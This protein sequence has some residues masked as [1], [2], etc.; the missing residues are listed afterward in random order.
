MQCPRDVACCELGHNTYT[1]HCPPVSISSCFIGADYTHLRPSVQCIASKQQ[2]RTGI[3][4][5]GMAIVPP[6]MAII[7]VFPH[8][9]VSK[10][11]R[12]GACNSGGVGKCAILGLTVLLESKRPLIVIAARQK[13]S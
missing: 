11:K 6:G 2:L 1:V 4:I 8:H 7:L 12:E 3:V 13:Y 5:L 10:L 9:T